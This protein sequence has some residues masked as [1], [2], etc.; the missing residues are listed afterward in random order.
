M[1]HPPR[2]YL[3]KQVDFKNYFFKKGFTFF[4]FVLFCNLPFLSFSQ[5]CANYA[6]VTRTTGITY[7]SIMSTGNPFSSW[8]NSGA[9]S[10][11]DNRSNLTN[12]G[13]NFWYNGTRY[14]Q[15]SVS[16]NGYM[17][18]SSATSNGTGTTAYGYQNTQFTA[19][20]TTPGSGGTLLT[21][22]P[23]YD[24]MTTLGGTDPLGISIRYELNGT[25]PNRAL[26]VEWTNM[27]VYGNTTPNLNFQVKVYET[28]G[29]IE[30]I[31]GSMTQGTPTWSYSCGINAS[32]LSATPTT[33]QLLTQQTANT[34]TF[35]N[36]VQNALATIPA[37]NTKLTF[38]PPT[39]T[40]APTALTFTAV[41]K[42]GMT[43][44]WTDNATNEVGYVI[45]NST[46]NITFNFVTQ[47]ASNSV[48][49]VIAG[50]FPSTTYYWQVYAVTEGK[51]SS[52]LLGTQATLPSGTVTSIVTGNWSAIGTWDCSC[53]PTTGDNVVIANG[54]TVTLDVNGSCNSLNVG[55]GFTGQ[56]T[57]GNSATAR[58]LTV[59]TDVTILMGAT[60]V[61]GATGA[62]HIMS[63]GGN[64]TNNGTFDLAPTATCVCN[65]TFNKNGN[66]ALSGTGAT[67]NF[68]R[69]TLNM[70]I[71]NTNVFNIA[72]NNFTVLPTNFLTLTNG[73]FKLSTATAAITPFTAAVTIPASAGIW[74]N[75]AGATISTTGGTMTLYGYVRATAGT[76]NVGSASDNNLT[77]YGGTITIDGGTM[78]IAG[79]LDRFGVAVLT[80]FTMSSGT[81][82]VATVGSTTA[83]EAPFRMDEVSSTFNM[84]G[85]III[86]RRPGAGNLGY[87]NTGGTIGTVS[88]GTLQIGDA[89]TPAAQTIQIN[90]SIPI[91]N[92]TISNGVAVTAQLSTN[93][94]TVKNN[95]LINSG[96]LNANALNITLGGNWTNSGTFTASTGTVT[97][98]SNTAAQTLTGATTFYNLIINNTF[99]TSPQITLGMNTTATN[100]L[101][102]TRGNINLAG[103]TMTLGTAAATPGTLSHAG[104]STNGWIYGGNFTRWFN[105]ATIADGA[106]AGLFPMGNSGT[107]FRPFRVSAP[108]TAPTTGGT[109]TLS[110]T[111]ATTVSTV[112][113][114]DD[115]LI[116]RRHNAFWTSATGNGLAGGT[117]NLRAEG[118]GFGTIAAVSGLRLTL[119]GSVVGTPGVNAG[120]TSN[121]QMNRTG[122]ALAGLSNNFYIGS[123]DGVNS[124]LPIELLSFNAKCNNGNV[125]IIWTTTSETNNDYF[126]IERSND[127]INFEA[128]G[129]IDGA[130]NSSHPINYSFDD[131]E[132]LTGTSYYRLK[133]TDFDGKYKY[134]NPVAVDCNNNNLSNIN[135]FPNP[136]TGNFIIRGFKQDADLT[137]YNSLGETILLTKINSV[138]AQVEID[139]SNQ[140]CGIYFIIV[141]FGKESDSIKMIIN[142]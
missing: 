33:S 69:I 68:N 76:I 116:V 64:L 18:F 6:P 135:I 89:S 15:F 42:T 32:T 80:F 93:S 114:M 19:A 4:V 10:S 70:G 35:N 48:S 94:L 71:S 128:I 96:T 124:P 104:A 20:G 73:T 102:M 26:T 75:N 130:D 23:I 91:Y 58:T 127:G 74:V 60:I 90:A 47:V 141:N 85:G 53:V 112:S 36:T 67:T 126:T 111:S 65:I 106:L 52:P 140:P 88:G 103:F 7:S 5:S 72:S 107:D 44:N 12:I 17:D 63:M 39:P 14:T 109:I 108:A 122:L 50:L 98:N 95:V 41:T 97:F 31:Y 105:T 37:T 131:V 139:L 117:Y 87:V 54:T 125:N 43:L 129:K 79:R 110:H 82:T 8:R 113:F 132:P 13:F 119:I 115:I 66:Q 83:G 30:F 136:N 49:A 92:L 57:I 134:F 123:V 9:T 11:D 22:A 61:T 25:A 78:N 142:R 40:A 3:C 133:Q 121:P 27:A 118:T 21:L 46:D 62:T 59:N 138:N 99:A 55:Q 120:T 16:T 29:V 38:T 2:I 24:D 101:T 45:Y 81:L 1:V 56:L 28:S 34:A 137:I 84:S 100:N 77:S 51:L 86:I